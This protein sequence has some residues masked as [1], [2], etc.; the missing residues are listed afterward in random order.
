MVTILL[1]AVRA[2][3]RGKE[4]VIVGSDCGFGT[5]AG[6]GAVDSEIAWAKLATLKESARRAA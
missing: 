3:R 1:F 2:G 6:L 4:R 5:F